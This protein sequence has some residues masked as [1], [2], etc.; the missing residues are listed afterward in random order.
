[1]NYILRL[2]GAL[3]YS[4]AGLKTACR[5]EA[6]FQTELFLLPVAI[7]IALYFGDSWLE[8]ALLIGSW[9]FVMVIELINSAIEAVVDR[10]G[11]ERHE[12][13]K[14]AKDLGSAAVLISLIIAALIWLAILF[15]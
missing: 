2:K 4:M 13:S 14:A 11:P 12:L 6:A 8:K 3:A 5:N 15:A 10:I 9:L 1:M 7:G